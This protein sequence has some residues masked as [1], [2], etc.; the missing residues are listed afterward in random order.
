MVIS[1]HSHEGIYVHIQIPITI[2]PIKLQ[3]LND[4]WKDGI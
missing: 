4:S 3:G 1:T 2:E